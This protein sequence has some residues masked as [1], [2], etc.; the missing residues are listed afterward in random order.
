[1]NLKKIIA[2]LLLANKYFY[3]YFLSPAAVFT[4]AEKKQNTAFCKSGVL[5][6][7]SYI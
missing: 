4:A 3:L 6:V 7:G 1:M 2:F 5:P